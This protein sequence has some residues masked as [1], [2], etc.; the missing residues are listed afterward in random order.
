MALTTSANWP[1]ISQKDLSLVFLNKFRGIPSMLPYILRFKRAEQGTEYLLETG[2]IGSPQAFTGS[3]FYDQVGEGY[4]K[5]IA[6]TQYTLG[7]ILTRQLMRNDLYGVIRSRVSLIA[8]SFRSLRETIGASPF[9]NANNT[10]F[11]MGDTLSLANSAHTS[12]NGGGTQSNT[13]SLALSA[14]N[15]FTALVAM[16]KLKTNRDQIMVNIPDTLLVPMDLQ[17]TAFEILQSMGKLDTANN[18]RNYLQNQFN[19]VVWDNYL[20]ST[21]GWFLLNSQINK[22]QCVFFEWEPTSFMRS[23][24]VDT[25]TSKVLGYTSCGVAF[26]EWR[27]IYQGNS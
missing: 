22:E 14:A 15:L 24:E 18:N 4:K 11:T 1:S 20:T 16:K 10:S 2:D 12:N 25:L 6:E 23:G 5:S 21:T 3:V 9:V 8:Q 27:G 19:L 17:Q 13:S 26:G 7:L